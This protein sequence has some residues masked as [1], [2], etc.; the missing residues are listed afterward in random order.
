MSLIRKAINFGISRRTFL[1]GVGASLASVPVLAGLGG[2]AEAASTGLDTGPRAINYRTRL[3]LLGTMGGV[4]WW[5]NSDRA[6]SSS[7]LVVGDAIYL[8]DLGQGATNRLTQ[9]F[10]TGSFVRL[11]DGTT[12]EDGSTT[13]LENVKAL[14]FTHLHMDHTSDYPAFLMIGAG[15][16]LA[17]VSGKPADVSTINV[18]GPCNRGSVDVNKTGYT[19]TIVRTDNPNPALYNTPGTKEMTNIIWQAYAQAVNDLTLDDGYRDFTALV[20]PIDIGTDIPVSFPIPCVNNNTCPVTPK[21]QIYPYPVDGSSDKNGVSVWATLVDHHQV[22]PAFAFRFDTPDGSVVFS[23]DTG[24]NT[25]G[26][27][28]ALAQG[29]EVLVHEVI[30]E[31]WIDQKFGP[32]RDQ[33]PLYQHMMSSHTTIG[34]VGGVASGCEVKTLVLNHIVPGNTPDAHLRKA[35]KDFTGRLII[36][37]DLMQIGIGKPGRN[38]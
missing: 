24:P 34:H 20:N 13:F 23:G 18:F 10:C 27:L 19:G 21:F 29:A 16:G 30:D 5:P 1:K 25:N 26:N 12:I 2:R 4:S 6:S 22:F 32:T 36:G 9:A 11:N 37:K 33:N 14:F 7:A 28:Q 35:K 17:G 38:G 31:A 8:I 3:V 15:A